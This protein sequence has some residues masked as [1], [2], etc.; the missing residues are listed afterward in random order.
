MEVEQEQRLPFLDV[1]VIRRPDGRLAHTVYRKSTHTDRYLNAASTPS[2][3]T[4][5]FNQDHLHEEEKQ[6]K[7]ALLANGYP[8]HAVKRVFKRAG[9]APSTLEKKEQ[10]LGTAFLPYVQGTT[11]KISRVLQKHQIKTIFHSENT[12]SNLL[13]CAKD[14]IP[15]ESQGI[16]EIPCTSCEQTYVGRTNRRISCRI[17]EH[18]AAINRQEPTST[19]VQHMKQRGHKIDLTGSRTLAK[20][21]H[22]KSRIYRE[23]IEIEKRPHIMNTRDD[24]QRLPSHG[25]LLSLL[26]MSSLE[27]RRRY[28]ENNGWATSSVVDAWMGVYGF[29]NGPH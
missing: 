14:N 17:Q 7:R 5:K 9:N 23:A 4:N 13:R 21:D 12:I 3:G 20:I 22:E 15:L 24:A 10:T 18:K 8:E 25:K 19:L 11:D 27:Q 6:L 16:Y 28:E 2:P 29:R 1:L 26:T